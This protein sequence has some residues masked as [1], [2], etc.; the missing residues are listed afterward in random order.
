MSMVCKTFHLVGR[1]RFVIVFCSPTTLAKGACPSPALPV[2]HSY[3]V[4]VSCVS[5]ASASILEGLQTL[6]VKA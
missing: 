3:H 5:Q 6:N 4:D 1:E 2:A